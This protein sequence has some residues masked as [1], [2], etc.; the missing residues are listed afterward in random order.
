EHP[1]E[2]DDADENINEPEDNDDQRGPPE[3]D[4]DD[5]QYSDFEGIQGLAMNI[6]A[7]EANDNDNPGDEGEDSGEDTSSSSDSETESSST[8]S[9]VNGHHRRDVSPRRL[10]KKSKKSKKAKKSK[11][12]RSIAS[13]SPGPDDRDDLNRSTKLMGSRVPGTT[14]SSS[15]YQV[16]SK[17]RRIFKNGWNEH[18]PLTTLTDKY[19]AKE[20]ED[21]E[22]ASESLLCF[23][24]GVWTSLGTDFSSSSKT[25]LS[26]LN[27]SCGTA[28]TLAS[29]RM[30]RGVR[31][32]LSGRI[33]ISRFDAAQSP[34]NSLTPVNFRRK[35]GT[36]SH[37]VRTNR[38][39][40]PP[41]DPLLEVHPQGKATGIPL[42]PGTPTPMTLLR[43]IPETR[44]IG[45]GTTKT[46]NLTKA[47][48][49]SYADP[50]TTNQ[51]NASPSSSSAPKTPSSY[52]NHP[53]VEP[54]MTQ[55]VTSTV[56]HGTANPNSA[57]IPTHAIS[58]TLVLSAATRNTTPSCATLSD[59]PTCHFPLPII[60]PLIATAWEAELL[61]ANALDEFRDIPHGIRYGF[62]MGTA[63]AL[64]ST[65]YIPPN[66][67]SATIRP[68]LILDNIRKELLERR[69]TGPFHPSRLEALIGPF[70]T[71]P[72]GLVPKSNDGEFRLIQ[73]FSY[74]RNDPHINSV[75]SSIDISTFSCNWGCFQQVVNIILNAP[76]GSLA[77]TLDVDSAFR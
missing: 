43:A 22:S 33:M 12:S 67:S 35:Y 28:I 69:Y 74:P 55:T 72:L 68:E 2:D 53:P 18:V 27:I 46:P 49:A 15:A 17:I 57:Q 59:L 63:T 47:T 37:D 62:D 1:D 19:C 34:T 5:A 16:P 6:A 42:I 66:H 39:S 45:F 73:D 76:S 8:S 56:I 65:S 48:A 71:S 64:P 30:T 20:A 24:E 54:D 7:D 38:L 44:T 75:N 26:I 10:R 60:T 40:C 32:G 13:S 58:A 11:K 51:P 3:G 50:S 29:W 36:S 70:R 77:A 41:L 4:D 61:R 31:T 23:H 14:L 25:T 21:G 52:P 9:S